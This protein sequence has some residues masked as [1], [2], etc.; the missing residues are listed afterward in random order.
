M[1]LT[2]II[3]VQNS[4]SSIVLLKCLNQKDSD[5][6]DV[7]NVKVLSF[8]NVYT[9]RFKHVYWTNLI[10]MCVEKTES[11]LVEFISSYNDFKHLIRYLI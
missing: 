2:L 3:I 9:S 4:K 5:I 7:E 11:C 1:L 6:E 8:V 10:K